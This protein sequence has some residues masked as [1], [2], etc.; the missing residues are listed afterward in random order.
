MIDNE[1]EVAKEE[2]SPKV[3]DKQK[4]GAKTKEVAAQARVV[5]T[6]LS[7]TTVR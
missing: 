4:L 2:V 1:D 6:T 3:K 5:A 7:P